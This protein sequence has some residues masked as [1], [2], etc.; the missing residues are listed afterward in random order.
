MLRWLAGKYIDRFAK[1]YD[2]DAA[3]LH[4]MLR[5]A[6]D[7]AFKFA[8]IAEVSNHRRVVSESA[9]FAAKLS[10]TLSEDCGPCAQLVVNMAREAGVAESDIVALLERNEP[11]MS[12]D[13]AL[14]F[15][16]AN[17]V[18]SRSGDDDAARDLVRAVWGEAGV[19]ELSVA[20][21]MS[22]V[23]P[24]LKAGMGYAKACRRVRVGGRDVAVAA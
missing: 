22:R 11:A 16:F 17:A 7:A 23:Y 10:A 6:P 21:A 8:R 14:G 13:I 12:R 18:L 20:I 15:R 1:R 4:A 24:V 2:Y 19:I 5:E 9:Y 3:Y